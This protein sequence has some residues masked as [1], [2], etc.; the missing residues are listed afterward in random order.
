VIAPATTTAQ[1]PALLSIASTTNPIGVITAAKVAT[2]DPSQWVLRVYQPTNEPLDMAIE[3]DPNI[4]PMFQSGGILNVAA[5]NAMEAAIDGG[6]LHL[7]PGP[8]SFTAPRALATFSLI[9]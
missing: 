1:L 5:V 8:D 4:A 9:Q 6:E 2:A 3:L 7:G